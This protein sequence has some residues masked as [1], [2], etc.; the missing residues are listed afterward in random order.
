[1]ENRW[2][3]GFCCC[4][5]TSV[6]SDPVRPHRRQPT[7]LPRPWDSP[8]K[9]TGVGCHFLLQCMEWKVKVKSLSR[10][11]LLA[12]PWTAA[13][14]APPS[15]GFARQEYWSGVP[16][17]SQVAKDN[18]RR[19]FI[20]KLA[21]A[22][23]VSQTWATVVP[24]P[25]W[26][27][28][29]SGQWLSSYLLSLTSL[30]FLYISLNP[31]EKGPDGLRKIHGEENWRNTLTLSGSNTGVSLTII[32]APVYQGSLTSGPQTS[33]SCQISS[34]VRLGIKC[35]I[36]IMHLNHLQTH[37]L[38]KCVK[39]LSSLKSVPGAKKVGTTALHWRNEIKIDSSL[40]KT[41]REKTWNFPGGPVVKTPCSQCRGPGFNSWSGN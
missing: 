3:T 5:V 16:L 41:S 19:R 27:W 13:Y 36:N 33:A 37:P 32:S 2:E 11:W 35:T 22:S 21:Q 8:G 12:T 17:P 18:Q 15:M 25:W 29:I 14:Q 1:M 23:L 34:S 30:C 6:V 31:K 7:R 9:N 20:Y 26:Q 28:P 4:C 38:H 40:N 39:K 10:V 24:A